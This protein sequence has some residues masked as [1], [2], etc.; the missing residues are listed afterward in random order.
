M[1]HGQEFPFIDDRARAIFKKSRAIHK[2]I[3]LKWL[4]ANRYIKFSHK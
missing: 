3:N 2:K 1:I 4:I